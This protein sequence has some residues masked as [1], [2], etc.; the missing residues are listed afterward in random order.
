MEN[1]DVQATL[2][3]VA[4]IAI[5]V[6]LAATFFKRTKSIPAETVE[7]APYK[8]ETPVAPKPVIEVD[9]VRVVEAAEASAIPTK[10]PRKPRAPKAEVVKKPAAKKTVAKKKISK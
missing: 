4:A 5:V 1:I 7:A 6:G 2:E 8:V 3:L 9:Q 10:A